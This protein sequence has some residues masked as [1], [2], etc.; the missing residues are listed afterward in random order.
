MTAAIIALTYSSVLFGSVQ[1][2][3]E[4][5]KA[6][7]ALP[8]NIITV[9]MGNFAFARLIA[10]W[11]GVNNIAIYLMI[12]LVVLT[13]LFVWISLPA[14][15]KTEKN[16]VPRPTLNICLIIRLFHLTT[17]APPCQVNLTISLN[18]LIL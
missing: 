2:W 16:T 1:C 4:W 3:T 10:N 12:S 6:L 13:T 18:G 7:K 14:A 8:D 5:L 17:K 11:S 15:K 9:D